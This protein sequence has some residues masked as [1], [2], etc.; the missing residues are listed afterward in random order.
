MCE[1]CKNEEGYGEIC[2]VCHKRAVHEEKQLVIDWIT[3]FNRSTFAD[4]LSKGDKFNEFVYVKIPADTWIKYM[5]E[6]MTPY[7]EMVAAI[8]KDKEKQ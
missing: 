6:S 3:S 4:L 5:R 8:M 7:D 2:M 1:L